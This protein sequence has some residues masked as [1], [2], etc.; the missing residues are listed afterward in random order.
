[1]VQGKKTSL[2]SLIDGIDVDRRSIWILDVRTASRET[3]IHKRERFNTSESEMSVRLKEDYA[4]I[5]QGKHLRTKIEYA[6]PCTKENL[7]LSLFYK[8][9]LF[10]LTIRM[11]I[12]QASQS[13]FVFVAGEFNLSEIVASSESSKLVYRQSRDR[14]DVTATDELCF[15]TRKRNAVVMRCRKGPALSTAPRSMDNFERGLWNRHG[16][17]RRNRTM[18][19]SNACSSVWRAYI[20]IHTLDM[21]GKMTTNDHVRRSACQTKLHPYSSADNLV[22][23][24]RGYRAARAPSWERSMEKPPKMRTREG[25]EDDGAADNSIVD[26]GAVRIDKAPGSYSIPPQYGYSRVSPCPSVTVAEL[27]N[28]PRSVTTTLRPPSV[29]S[30]PDLSFTFPFVSRSPS[31]FQLPTTQ[32]NSRYAVDPRLS[33]AVGRYLTILE[34]NHHIS[35]IN[36]LDVPS[37][38][39]ALTATD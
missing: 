28:V 27:M 34:S 21:L 6:V 35:Y 2:T 38:T 11:T 32:G 20:V 5:L 31:S 3:S 22:P 10:E 30:D 19:G 37:T 9:H 25:G 29:P 7:I 16:Q 4:L 12:S 33:S 18:S 24:L 39:P 15:G 13:S 1:M 17:Y 36:P 26:S 14:D 8:T 23:V